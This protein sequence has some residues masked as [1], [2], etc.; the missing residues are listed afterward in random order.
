MVYCVAELRN[1]KQLVRLRSAS[2]PE[3]E[4]AITSVL[5]GGAASAGPGV[6]AVRLGEERECSPT[7][8]AQLAWRLREFLSLRRK[9]LFGYSVLIASISEERRKEEILRG[10]LETGDRMDQLWISP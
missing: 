4:S 1:Y 2:L 8:V 7:A 6:W 3:V 9:D 5:G 10:L